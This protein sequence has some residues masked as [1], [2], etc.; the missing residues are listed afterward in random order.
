MTASGSR[1]AGP[2]ASIRAAR[3]IHSRQPRVPAVRAG[4]RTVL[5]RDDPLDVFGDQC[6]Q[7]LPVAATERG[8][9]VTTFAPSEAMVPQ[10]RTNLPSTSTMHVSQDWIGPSWG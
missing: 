2:D 4:Q 9:D 8:E 5:A 1:Y 3:A 10:A 6:Q 7:P